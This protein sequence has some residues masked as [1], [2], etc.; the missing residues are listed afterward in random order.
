[1]LQTIR[2]IGPVL[3]LFTVD[4]ADWGVTEVAAALE[5]PRSSAHALLSSLVETGLLRSR[6]RG[7]YQIGWRVVEL[8]ATLRGT[9]DVRGLAQPVLRELARRSGETAHLAVW[10]R[11]CGLYVDRIVGDHPAS[12][13]GM[14][15]GVRFEPHCCAAGK[16]MLAFGDPAEMR[17]W[18]TTAPLR[19][20]TANTITDRAVLAGQLRTAQ[21]VG[22]AVD[23]GEAVTEVHSIAAPV[24]DDCGALVATTSL[25]APANRFLPRNAELKRAVTAAAAD[26]SARLAESKTRK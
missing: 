7:R 19:P 15:A 25:M 12:V 3:D 13:I 8:G 18:L 9:L 20:V 4:C 1:M 22:C 14:R 24:R 21:L 16:A 2:K 26:L 17:R 5:I 10:D 11:G 6:G 23:A